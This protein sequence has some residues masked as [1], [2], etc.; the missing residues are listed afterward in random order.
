MYPIYYLEIEVSIRKA[1][2]TFTKSTWAV[3]KY[4]NSY[5]I[6]SKDKKTMDRL[7]EELYGS[8]YKGEKRIAVTKIKS[9][10]KVG[11]SSFL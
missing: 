7:D 8:N 1:K 2:N 5:D 6:M 11:E 10:K 4:D 9:I 3:S